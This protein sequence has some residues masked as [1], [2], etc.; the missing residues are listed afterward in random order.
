MLIIKKKSEQDRNQ[1]ENKERK[2]SAE[3]KK[4]ERRQHN[5]YVIQLS[6]I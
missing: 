1:Q 3:T 2:G 6:Y 5:W 4:L